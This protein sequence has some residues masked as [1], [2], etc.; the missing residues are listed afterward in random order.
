MSKKKKK[1]NKKK[2]VYDGPHYSLGEELV[3]SISHGL[4]AAFSIPA[5]VLMIIKAAHHSALAVVT[6]IIF[7]VC[8][9]VLYTMSCIYHALSPNLRGK[10]V[11]RILDHCNVFLLVYGTIIPISLL[12]MSGAARWWFF[13]LTTFVTIIGIVANAVDMKKFQVLSVICHL[14]SGWGALLFTK[15]LIAG[16]GTQGLLFVILGG[17]MYTIGAILYGIGSK[18]PY[19]HSVFHFFCIAGSIFHFIAVY[20]YC[21]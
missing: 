14:I 13:G 15:P 2:Y 18:I 3:N 17:V 19:M 12:G 6:S 10:A 20:G 7:G 5:L 9:I 21:L 11:I 16:I 8:L 1:K 4:A